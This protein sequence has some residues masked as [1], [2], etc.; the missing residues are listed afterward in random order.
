M[1]VEYMLPS[2]LREDTFGTSPSLW[3]LEFFLSILLSFALLGI[4]ALFIWLY[5]R[6]KNDH[7]LKEKYGHKSAGSFKGYWARY[8]GAVYA[9][10]SAMF[11]IFGILVFFWA[12]GIIDPT[13]NI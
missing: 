13:Y 6:Q 4:G 2:L 12:F 7:G 11:I 8:R 10:L 5:Y 3:S 9:F 1:N